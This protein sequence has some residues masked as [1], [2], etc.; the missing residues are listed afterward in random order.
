M[1]LDVF[2]TGCEVLRETPAR[3]RLLSWESHLEVANSDWKDRIKRN[4]SEGG[5][6]EQRK[7]KGGP[8]PTLQ[9]KIW[10]KIND[11]LKRLGRG[12]VKK[13]DT[14]RNRDFGAWP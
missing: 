11:L 12:Q 14:R 5:R 8:G 6:G 13:S 9:L 2:C 10:Q 1:A 7:V 3:T 4:D